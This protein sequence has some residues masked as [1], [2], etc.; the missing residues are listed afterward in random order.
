LRDYRTSWIPVAEAADLLQQSL[1]LSQESLARVASLTPAPSEAAGADP[2]TPDPA[3]DPGL[4]HT[5]AELAAILN[6][7]A[8]Q[9]VEQSQRLRSRVEQAITE[10]MLARGTFWG[11][12]TGQWLLGAMVLSA[13]LG[14]GVLAHAVWRTRVSPEKLERMELELIGRTDRRAA[15]RRCHERVRGLLDLADSLCRGGKT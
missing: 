13:L 6:A 10:G 12:E 11:L 8:Q 4:A 5:P 2:P 7:R 9:L 1:D 14:S 15:V 3:V